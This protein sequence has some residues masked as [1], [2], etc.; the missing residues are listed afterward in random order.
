MRSVILVFLDYSKIDFPNTWRG[1]RVPSEIPENPRGLKHEDRRIESEHT[2]RRFL[3]ACGIVIVTDNIGPFSVFGCAR[4]SDVSLIDSIEDAVRRARMHG[5]DR[6]QLPAVFQ[7]V[8]REGQLKNEVAGPIVSQVK[9]ARP[10]VDITKCI[11]EIPSLQSSRL[12]VRADRVVASV[13]G[14]VVE[15][16]R[17][18]VSGPELN[19]FSNTLIKAT[20]SEL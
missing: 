1:Q 16:L 13:I 2:N 5:R 10:V 11:G 17:I 6:G 14:A 8:P 4:L 3:N 19:V 15:T 18:R 20:W 9:I 12:P 7:A